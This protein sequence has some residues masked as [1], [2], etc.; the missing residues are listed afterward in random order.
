[1]SQHI[2]LV[3]HAQTGANAEG[4]YV[5]SLDVKLDEAGLE[6]ARQLAEWAAVARI[7][8]IVS[9]PAR[10]A[11]RTAMIVGTHLDTEP[12]ADERLRELDFGVAEGRTI[13]ALREEDP[14]AV[15]RFET[16][17]VTY[18][19]P[20]GEDP[21][22]AIGRMRA[23]VEEVRHLQGARPL[24]V[25]HNT[26]LRLLVCHVLHVPLEQYRR[27]L[28]LAEHCAITELT[29]DDDTIA[30]RRFNARVMP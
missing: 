3:R 13:A 30:L 21:R 22:E 24:V 27:L 6:Q 15:A 11:W 9:S 25:T 19:L 16:D 10:R 8:V 23:A 4:R 17:P 5:G 29:M 7:D 26:V 12:R 20:G 28:P 1:V 18:H 2:W 14:Q